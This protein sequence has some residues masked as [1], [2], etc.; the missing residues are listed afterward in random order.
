MLSLIAANY[1]FS[2]TRNIHTIN[3]RVLAI[4]EID[5]E[6]LGRKTDKEKDLKR[7]KRESES[8]TTLWF[9]NYILLYPTDK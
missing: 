4:K 8:L 7:D 1:K 5:N 6:E 3:L 2:G 9:D